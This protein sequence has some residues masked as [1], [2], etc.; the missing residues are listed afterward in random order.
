MEKDQKTELMTK[1]FGKPSNEYRVQSEKTTS[2]TTTKA[3]RKSRSESIKP[4]QMWAEQLYIRS[5]NLA[6]QS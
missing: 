3:E 5:T 1:R 2:K 6:H 4:L